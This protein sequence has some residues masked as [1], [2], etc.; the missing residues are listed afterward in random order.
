MNIQRI[1]ALVS[2]N[3]QLAFRGIDPLI[4]LCYWPFFD[5]VLWGFT[6][7]WVQSTGQDVSLMWLAGLVLW[8]ACYR[9]NFDVSFN[10][11]NELWS[12]N[13]VNLFATPLELHEWIASALI[14]G[15]I[16][17][18]ITMLYGGLL[19]YLLYGVNIFSVG[20]FIVP[21]YLLVLVFGWSTG[22]VAAGCLLNWGQKVQKVV[23]VFGWCLLPFSSIF[24]PLD[25]LPPVGCCICKN[26]ATLLYIREPQNLYCTGDYCM[27]C[28]G[29]EPCIDNYV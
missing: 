21:L 6:S 17:T 7:R 9:A 25:F 4:D 18:I 5:L 8:Q 23:W 10:L 19:A 13:V 3:L 29:H 15:T 27:V 24:F 1:G 2:R 11:L 14:V 12:R 26:A 20:W 22:F 28:L 16:N